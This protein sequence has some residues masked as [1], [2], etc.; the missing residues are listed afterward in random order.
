L[1]SDSLDKAAGEF[2]NQAFLDKL[3]EMIGSGEI[4]D[5]DIVDSL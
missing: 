1:F 2:D 4:I 5:Q 3:M